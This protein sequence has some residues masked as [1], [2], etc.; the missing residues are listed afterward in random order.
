MRTLQVNEALR[1]ALRQEMESDSRVFAF[2]EDVGVYG[3][4]KSLSMTSASSPL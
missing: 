4:L 1:E 2:G 3:G